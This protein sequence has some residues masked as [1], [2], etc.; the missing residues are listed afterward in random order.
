[1]FMVSVDVGKSFACWRSWGRLPQNASTPQLATPGSPA[2]MDGQ[3][4]GWMDGWMDILKEMA[5]GVWFMMFY[6]F[7]GI[8]PDKDEL[9]SLGIPGKLS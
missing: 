1:M 3:M 9:F 6:M 5:E 8:V 2:Q 4:D 7:G